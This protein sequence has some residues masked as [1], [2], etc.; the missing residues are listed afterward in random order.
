M[1]VIADVQTFQIFGKILMYPH[2]LFRYR[3]YILGLS[4]L[5]AIHVFF[6]VLVNNFTK[7]SKPCTCLPDFELDLTRPVDLCIAI[8]RSDPYC[9]LQ[10]EKVYQRI[11]AKYGVRLTK[12]LVLS[13]Q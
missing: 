2:V 9:F 6:R 3:L 12:P 13:F 4:N 10:T 8:L 5:K 1:P 11:K 7:Q